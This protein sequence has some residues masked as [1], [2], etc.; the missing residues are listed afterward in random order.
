MPIRETNIGKGK[1]DFLELMWFIPGLQNCYFLKK[2]KA[3]FMHPGQSEIS[4]IPNGM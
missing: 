2:E 1:G 3:E 4:N